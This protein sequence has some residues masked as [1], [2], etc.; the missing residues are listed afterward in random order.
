MAATALT[1]QDATLF[2]GDEITF[3]A[4]D[5]VN[6]NSIPAEPNIVVLVK[7]TDATEGDATMSSVADEY[8]RTGDIV[9]TLDA[10]GEIA[11]LAPTRP[12]VFSQ[13]SGADLGKILLAWE[14]VNFTVAAVRIKLK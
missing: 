8:A 5:Q 9:A 13:K 12:E 7:R 14:D 2:G 10:D 1:V 11:I 4:I 3:G 6:G